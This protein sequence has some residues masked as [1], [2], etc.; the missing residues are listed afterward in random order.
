MTPSSWPPPGSCNSPPRLHGSHGRPARRRHPA[1][2]RRR[3]ARPA[4]LEREIA[5]IV[6]LGIRI[7][8]EPPATGSADALVLGRRRQPVRASANFPQ[9]FRASTALNR[10][11]GAIVRAV[12]AA[13][14]LVGS[15]AN[16][17]R[18][19]NC[20]FR[21]ARGAHNGASREACPGAAPL[22]HLP[23]T[24]PTPSAPSSSRI[25]RATPR[26]RRD[27]PPHRDPPRRTPRRFHSPGG[28]KAGV[29]G[30]T[31]PLFRERGAAVRGMTRPLA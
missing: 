27:H 3:P 22:L 13:R 4:I 1:R 31:R 12:A 5:A 16:P 9:V 28:E 11:R 25:A 19:G 29:R 21:P 20:S 14:F 18:S 10:C 6:R 15:G 24:K 8:A 26:R 23:A 7:V 2:T 17:S 30:T